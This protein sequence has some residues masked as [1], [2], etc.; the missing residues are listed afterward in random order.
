MKKNVASFI[1][2]A[3]VGFRFASTITLAIGASPHRRKLA[4]ALLGCDGNLAQKRAV[5]AMNSTGL[6]DFR[7]PP[8]IA[9][10]LQSAGKTVGAAAI[11]AARKASKSPPGSYFWASTN[12]CRGTTH[13]GVRGIS[14]SATLMPFWKAT[15]AIYPKCFSGYDLAYRVRQT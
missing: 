2:G 6:G 14:N 10:S 3:T 5:S 7:R 1:L 13:N 9:G 11:A 8:R 15:S 4:A 12:S